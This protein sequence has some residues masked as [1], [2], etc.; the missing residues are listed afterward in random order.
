MNPPG[1]IPSPTPG[2]PPVSAALCN[3]LPAPIIDLWVWELRSNDRFV[4]GLMNVTSRGVW[5]LVTQMDALFSEQLHRQA[6]LTLLKISVFFRGEGLKSIHPV[7][8]MHLWSVGPWSVS[9]VLPHAVAA[10]WRIEAVA[11]GEVEVLWM[12]AVEIKFCF[13]QVHLLVM[14]G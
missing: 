13:I 11:E 8:V 10:V 2:E 5:D 14:R 1:E 7:T 12:W 3:R 4:R 6:S 9:C